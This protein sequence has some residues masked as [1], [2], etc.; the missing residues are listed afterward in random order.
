MEASSDTTP[1][2]CVPYCPWKVGNL[3]NACP[4]PFDLP[5]Q[6]DTGARKELGV[7]HHRSMGTAN[8]LRLPIGAYGE[9]NTVIC[10]TFQ[11]KR[12]QICIEVEGLLTKGAIQMVR[13]KDSPGFYSRLFLV[14]KKG[15]QYRSVIN[16]RPLNWWI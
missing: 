7:H 8:D 12:E 2:T 10:P 4:S 6:E 1:T 14:P 9:P 16:L 13:G 3:G 5:R 15:G 11:S